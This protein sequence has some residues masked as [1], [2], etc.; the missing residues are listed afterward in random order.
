MFSLKYHDIKEKIPAHRSKICYYVLVGNYQ[1]SS[2]SAQSFGDIT[3]EWASDNGEISE[4]YDLNLESE[5]KINDTRP[6]THWPDEEVRLH[7]CIDGQP[8][9]GLL[10]EEPISIAWNYTHD[11]LR[12]IAKYKE[13][14]YFPAFDINN[15]LR[16]GIIKVVSKSK[17]L[18]G[19]EGNKYFHVYTILE[20]KGKL[21]DVSLSQDDKWEDKDWEEDGKFGK[22]DVFSYKLLGDVNETA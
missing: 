1:L 9:W 18:V 4:Y 6:S 7:M 2:S 16:E 3:Y 21:Y 15:L 14:N 17:T 19:E 11:I 13:G 20:Y 22:V 12:E 10:R 5:F 8:V